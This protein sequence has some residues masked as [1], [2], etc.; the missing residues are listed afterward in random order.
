MNLTEQQKKAMAFQAAFLRERIEESNCRSQITPA[1]H[2]ERRLLRWEKNAGGRGGKKSFLRRLNMEGL[3]EEQA[4]RLASEGEGLLKGA[5]PAYMTMIDDLLKCL[6]FS[7][8]SAFSDEEN[9]QKASVLPFV[10]YAEKLLLFRLEKHAESFSTEA[11]RD[12]RD[13]LTEALAAVSREVWNEKFRLF[14]LR[15]ES[16]GFLLTM[17]NQQASHY[18]HLFAEQ[19]LGG[20]W[21]EIFQEFPLLPRL[22]SINIQNWICNMAELV[23]HLSQDQEELERRFYNSNPAGIITG[24]KGNMGDAHNRGKSVLLLRFS[25]GLSIV[26]KPRSLKVDEMF[27]RLQSSLE[28]EGFPCS[29]R[30][31]K[32]WSRKDHGWA[33]FINHDAILNQEEAAAY[34]FRMGSLFALVYILGG[35]DFHTENLIASGAHPVLIDL[36]T[37][38][39]Y[40]VVPFH[41]DIREMIHNSQNTSSIS[42]S[43]LA[44]GILP[45]WYPSSKDLWLDLGA[46]T[47]N[48]SQSVPHRNG[49]H[50]PVWE[51]TRE[52]IKGF[53]DV[54]HFFIDNRNR[55]SKEWFQIVLQ[56]ED[57]PLRF[58]MRATRVYAQM[59]KKVTGSQ[60][61]KDGFLYS[62]E[63]ER[64]AAPYFLGVSHD[65]AKELWPILL[66]ERSAMEELDIPM[67]FGRIDD[68]GLWDPERKL[69]EK[70]FENSALDRVI[71][72]IGRLSENDL[73]YQ[74]ELIE[75]SLFLRR[76]SAHRRI[77][78]PK[79][80]ESQD[81]NYDKHWDTH[82][83]IMAA[84]EIYEALQEEYPQ[85][86]S[87]RPPG[88]VYQFNLRN[89]II[90][91]APVSLSYYDGL[92]GM[93]LFCAALYKL[94]R[95]KEVKE[96]ALRWIA[97]LRESIHHREYPIPVER[98]PLGMSHG[99][100]GIL[101]AL[102][103]MAEYLDDPTLMDD[104]FFLAEM[105]K[106]EQIRSEERVD[107]Y[108]GISGLLFAASKLIQK[109]NHR[110]MYILADL[111]GKELI[112]RQAWKLPH[113]RF[114]V[115]HT[116]V[117][118]TPGQTTGFSDQSGILYSLLLWQHLLNDTETEAALDNF[119]ENGL[120]K[121]REL[122]DKALTERVSG[123]IPVN[124][125]SGLAGMGLVQ[126][127][128]LKQGDGDLGRVHDMSDR[129]LCQDL[130]QE[131]H[132]CC[133]SAGL[134]DWW[135]EAFPLTGKP[136]CLVKARE[137]MFNM[138]QDHHIGT[139]RSLG[140]SRRFLRNPSL[141]QGSAGIGYM[142][143]RCSDPEKIISIFT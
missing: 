71:K 114:Y 32:T 107:W 139:F 127:L 119:L 19:L 141:F 15:R 42:D 69:V 116:T 20:D 9:E 100:G 80:T 31:P 61:L 87:E 60:Y 13:I 126:L 131:E 103:I 78:L 41:D 72:R 68:C 99:I 26:Y 134:A 56:P 46:L 44:L 22:I 18:R 132:L 94:N 77:P 105:I 64:F 115:R 137:I 2:P 83:F 90:T 85:E 62:T 128:L 65:K 81:I 91:L 108:N 49:E 67:F 101:H 37:I 66:S 135:L 4:L 27:I 53:C 52:L 40:E 102:S 11:F 106:P 43:V 120:K 17:N 34:Y 45:V 30:V 50:V 73:Q 143:L 109:T 38:L 113:H 84:E 74:T 92:L 36:E 58:V 104:V 125:C 1:K 10:L 130:V 121:E 112:R 110:Q 88:M 21:N 39:S 8:D 5:L 138:I 96:T 111:C 51:Y 75:E 6:P 117:E 79:E 63:I 82:H 33:E 95:R 118:E 29:L 16:M 55:L 47:G 98:M 54:Y 59:L 14:V 7:S 70:Y 23:F 3:S 28:Q 124:I 123:Q 129:I 24:I 89:E 140:R 35:N 86:K 93:A 136:E 48:R 122:I 57:A 76:F 12:A 142:L 97:P 133:G 25:E